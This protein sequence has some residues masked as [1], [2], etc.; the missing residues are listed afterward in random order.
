MPREK[1]YASEAEKKA[2]Y[3]ERKR[4]ALAEPGD[5]E[6]RRASDA[7]TPE[8]S[9]NTGLAPGSASAREKAIMLGRALGEHEARSRGEVGVAAEQRI[10]RAASYAAWEFDGKPDGRSADYDR[11]FKLNPPD[12]TPSL[13]RLPFRRLIQAE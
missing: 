9:G 10:A 5:S 13:A 6:G 8:P 7:A 3:R 2:A 1:I 11:E 4:R 12:V